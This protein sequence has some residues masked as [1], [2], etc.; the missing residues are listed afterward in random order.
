MVH[1]L[2]DSSRR[3][4]PPAADRGVPPLTLRPALPA[5]DG[6]LF[7]V[8]A[9]SG[10]GGADAPRMGLLRQQFDREDRRYRETFPAADYLV[11]LRG[12]QP[13]GRLYVDHGR[14]RIRIL[15]LALLPEHRNGG[16]GSLLLT[17]LL[18]E[19][20]WMDKPLQV[21]VPR[22]H[23]SLHLLERFGFRR[24]GGSRLR[25]VLERR[26]GLSRR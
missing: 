17:S 10:A 14:K 26:P 8:Y 1:T 22:F 2:Q 9:G 4:P 15:D 16:L 24:I 25:L 13:V 3:T 11:V 18:V 20:D 19:A 12:E 6:F 23:R 21:Q 7:R 5:D